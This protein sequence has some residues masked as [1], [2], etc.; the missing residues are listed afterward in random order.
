M[1][2]LFIV[3]GATVFLGIFALGV[4]QL[5]VAG[6]KKLEDMEREDV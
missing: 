2:T 1:K 4:K 6:I 3:L 5:V